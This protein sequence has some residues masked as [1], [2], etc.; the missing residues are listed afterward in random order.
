MTI[1]ELEQVIR[2]YILD[3][4]G[5]QYIG[6]IKILELNP[7]GYSIKLDMGCP[8]K[9]LVIYAELEDSKFLKFLKEELKIKRFNLINFGQLQLTYPVDCHPINTSCECNDKR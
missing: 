8:E 2:E 1:T 5:K 3:I 7:V 4:Y 6:K 9:P